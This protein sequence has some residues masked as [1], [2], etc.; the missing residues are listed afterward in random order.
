MIIGPLAWL[1]LTG[2]ST[3]E[4]ACEGLGL[5]DACETSA[6][7]T[8]GPW[9]AVAVFSDDGCAADD[10]TWAEGWHV[11]R[12]EG[13]FDLQWPWDVSAFCALDGS[14]FACADAVT[15]D[16]TL[17]LAGSFD[18]ASS[19][20]A[21]LKIIGVDCMSEAD[22]TLRAAWKD[23]LVPADGAC[24]DDFGAYGPSERSETA[25]FTVHN[26]TSASVGLYELGE[27]APVFVG[28]IPAG[29][30]LETSGTLENYYTLG[31]GAE[32]SAC[33][34]FFRL[35]VDGQEIVWEGGS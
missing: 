5:G 6:G 17:M 29:S 30:A 8:R 18:S 4:A 28:D 7:P 32:E 1:A 14:S 26:R 10:G 11:T 22:L 9:R 34:L 25:G 15:P 21:S 33:G 31:S 3:L 20:A 27:G 24:P 13:G 23:G 2:C 16:A 35:S 12:A 19:G